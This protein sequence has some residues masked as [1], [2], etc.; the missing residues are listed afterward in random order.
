MFSARIGFSFLL[1]FL[2]DWILAGEDG[3]ARYRSGDFRLGFGVGNV[4][5]GLD[6]E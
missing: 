3:M 5:L 4:A 2:I 1:V 6:R